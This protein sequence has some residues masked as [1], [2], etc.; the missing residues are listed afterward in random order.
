MLQA[1]SIALPN[2]AVAITFDHDHICSSAI[3]HVEL[4]RGGPASGYLNRAINIS[5]LD[6]GPYRSKSHN[7]GRCSV[8]NVPRI[9][10]S[11]GSSRALGS[12]HMRP[13]MQIGCCCGERSHAELVTG[14]GGCLAIG[15]RAVET[16][17]LG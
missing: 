14:D 10:R 12:D 15:Q 1:V 11:L 9:S 16:P 6:S 2:L 17:V 7:R 4:K 13:S 8:G 3:S 5:L